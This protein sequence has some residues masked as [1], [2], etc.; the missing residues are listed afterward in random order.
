MKT[1]LLI[2]N[3]CFFSVLFGRTINNHTF[4]TKVKSQLKS[5][6]LNKASNDTIIDPH[7][8]TS[9]T[10]SN[11]LFGTKNLTI[12]DAING[13]YTGS[14]PCY[15]EIADSIGT[16]KRTRISR[17]N[18]HELAY[19]KPQLIAF[20]I[21]INREGEIIYRKFNFKQSKTKDINT[22]RK[23]LELLAEWKFAKDQAAPK[24]E[25]GTVKISI[26]GKVNTL[27]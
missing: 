26:G 23:A 14:T 17:S 20:D 22:I 15:G 21:C 24:K 2:L 9:S 7:F 16:L 1:T 12:K 5:L 19:E 13:E 25:C 11:T 3:I 6:I 27:K 18:M 10:D 4:E 8:N